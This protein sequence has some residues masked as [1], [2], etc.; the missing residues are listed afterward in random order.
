[1]SW[2]QSGHTHFRP[3][4]PKYFSMNFYFP[5]ICINMQKNQTFSSICSRDIVDLK[6]LQSDWPRAFWPISQE[7]YSQVWDLCNNTINNINFFCR[8]NSEK[9]NA[10]FSNAIKKPYSWPIFCHFPHFGGKNF[11]FQKIRLFHA[12]YHMGLPLT[13]CWVSEKTNEPI[14]R[15]HLDGKTDGQTLIHRTLPSTAGG[16]KRNKGVK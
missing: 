8:P 5:W 14:P 3:Y 15:K 2:D 12:Q 1:M 9:I 10:K 6:I 16:P 7:I 4:P 11:F 13:P